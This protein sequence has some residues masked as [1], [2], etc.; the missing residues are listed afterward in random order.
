MCI[1]C[2]HSCLDHGHVDITIIVWAPEIYV[3]LQIGLNNRH[4]TMLGLIMVVV[5]ISWII[6]RRLTTSQ[7]NLTFN[8]VCWVVRW[9]RVQLGNATLQDCMYLAGSLPS[10]PF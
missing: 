5:G 1:D 2:I 7:S 10:N 9:S 4:Q 6:S 8:H 3:E